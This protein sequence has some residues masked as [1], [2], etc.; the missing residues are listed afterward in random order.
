MSQLGPMWSKCSSQILWYSPLLMWTELPF[1]S[2]GRAKYCQKLSLLCELETNIALRVLIFQPLYFYHIVMMLWDLLFVYFLRFNIAAESFNWHSAVLLSKCLSMRYDLFFLWVTWP[3]FPLNHNANSISGSNIL[4]FST[5]EEGS[6]LFC[7]RGVVGSENSVD[8]EY[9][10][11]IQNNRHI[12]SDPKPR[13]N[14]GKFPII[15][16]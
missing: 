3:Y 16:H 6:Q 9:Q 10:F 13:E 1:E 4:W 8:I 14:N 12:G 15:S 7:I 2:I 5:V 11:H